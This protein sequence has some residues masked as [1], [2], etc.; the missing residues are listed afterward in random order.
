MR[1]AIY[2]R[3]S[4]LDQAREGYSLAA[5]EKTLRKWCD[6]HRHEVY[7]VYEDAG[8]S[9]KDIAHRPAMQLLIADAKSKKFDLVLFWA[10]SRFTRSVSDLYTTLSSFSKWEVSLRSH[11]EAFD[12]STPFGRAMIG[13]IGIFAQLE[14][15]LTGERVAAAMQER[16][17]QGGLTTHL[18][19]GY[20]YVKATKSTPGYLKINP[21]ESKQVRFIFDE[22]LRTESLAAVVRACQERDYRG[23]LGKPLAPSTI[24]K[25]LYKGVRYT[26]K[27]VFHGQVCPGTAPVIISEEV[28]EAVQRVIKSK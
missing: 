16:A 25:V 22:Y 8:I 5:Q 23:K 11:T 9:G 13:I 28:F 27:N 18:M 6:D 10:L 15:E 24:R 14:R 19:L 7:Q 2:I 4:S 20:D 26:G 3:V 17:H 21:Q 12:T 1:V